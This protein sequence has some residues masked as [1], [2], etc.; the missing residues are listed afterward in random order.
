MQK[1]AEDEYKDRLQGITVKATIKKKKP[2]LL[3]KAKKFINDEILL[4]KD[5]VRTKNMQRKPNA[6]NNFKVAENVLE[7][8]NIASG[9]F[10]NRLSPS[11]NIGLI[12]DVANG[13]NFMESWF[14]NN[15]V[16]TDKFAKEHPYL[17]FGANI[18]TDALF[19][20]KNV[21]DGLSLLD[22]R[23][24]PKGRLLNPQENTLTRNIGTGTSGYEDALKSG[25]IRGNMKPAIEGTVKTIKRNAQKL[26]E[27]GVDEEIIK[28]Y[29]GNNIDEKTFNILKPYF[30]KMYSGGSSNGKVNL[31]RKSHPIAEAKDWKEYSS[32][33][34]E[35]A[36]QQEIAILAQNSRRVN[37]VT[38]GKNWG[39][40][41]MATFAYPNENL[42]KGLIFPGDF[43]VNVK[44]AHKYVKDAT[45][46]GHL[47]EHPTT[48]YPLSINNKDVNFYVR[49]DG[50]LTGKQY[51]IKIPKV[52]VKL[53]KKHYDRT[54]KTLIKPSINKKPIMNTETIDNLKA[55]DYSV[56]YTI[57]TINGTINSKRK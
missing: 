23:G 14:G 29:T 57:G 19:N 31:I 41:N 52:A 2:T 51:K 48:E 24:A 54:G 43:T 16:V 44:N 6:I 47:K 34:A 30:E 28:Q 35:Q 11:Q 3:D 13:K 46:Y 8:A 55:I 15:G 10:I 53:D 1:V 27:Y 18:L 4:N 40:N 5:N 50:L 9:G 56:P 45:S 7:A 37:G 25:I 36:N 21:G 49:K 22:R 26:K 32:K 33:V 39:S 38:F 20:P 42:Q 17:S 12:K